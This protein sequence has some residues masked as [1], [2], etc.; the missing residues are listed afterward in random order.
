MASRRQFRRKWARARIRWMRRAAARRQQ[1]ELS[2]EIGLT[3]A[4]VVIGIAVAR[5][6]WEEPVKVALVVSL[7]TLEVVFLLFRLIMRS[8]RTLAA[9]SLAVIPSD[10]L[11][12]V[13]YRHFDRKRTSLLRR[14]NRL[15]QRLACGLEKHEMYEELTGLT[16]VVT[17]HRA[18]HDDAEIFAISSVNIVDFEIE[19]L[20]E[21]YLT[22]NRNAVGRHV[23]VRRLFL[24]DESPDGNPV[25]PI[26]DEHAKALR[27]S[28]LPP[29][30]GVRWLLKKDIAREEDRNHDF[31]LFA[32]SV[33][34]TQAPYVARYELTQDDEQIEWADETFDRLWNDP[35]A[36]WV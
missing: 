5:T 22:A 4:L 2:I 20:A 29:Q 36:H 12:P 8:I 9:D 30:S 28:G 6:N 34:V 21:I 18:G 7:G 15:A 25:A 23:L 27:D 14:A 17:A 35:N 1:I 24:L 16:D 31:A 11:A 13:L 19:P 26:I 33:L 3:A 32:R 10:G